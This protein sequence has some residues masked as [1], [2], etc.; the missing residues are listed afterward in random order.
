[1]SLTKH[2]IAAQVLLD[3]VKFLGIR[4]ALSCVMNV[5]P[6]KIDWHSIAFAFGLFLLAC[7]ILGG[8]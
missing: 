8:V 7:S 3:V 5:D 4:S 6:D 2:A 1:M